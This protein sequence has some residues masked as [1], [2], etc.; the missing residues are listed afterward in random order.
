MR[1]LQFLAQ[2]SASVQWSIFHA[3]TAG[4]LVMAPRPA[5]LCTAS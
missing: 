4:L 5:G 1:E 2:A 3:P